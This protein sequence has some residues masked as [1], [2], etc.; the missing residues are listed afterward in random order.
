M[1]IQLDC[2]AVD[3]AIELDLSLLAPVRSNPDPKV[4]ELFLDQTTGIERYQ[5][6][7][8][9]KANFQTIADAQTIASAEQFLV[10]D[11]QIR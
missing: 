11:S 2:S 10:G 7:G 5:M 3:F 9:T 8:Q 4:A 1:T 6:G